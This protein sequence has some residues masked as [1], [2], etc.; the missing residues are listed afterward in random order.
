MTKADLRIH[1]LNLLF[2]ANHEMRPRDIEQELWDSIEHGKFSRNKKS[3]HVQ[4]FRALNSLV[5]EQLIQRKDLTKRKKLAKGRRK[6]RAKVQYSIEDRGRVQ[7][8]LAANAVGID[9]LKKPKSLETS[10]ILSGKT[11]EGIVQELARILLDIIER[12]DYTRSAN[13]RLLGPII[14]GF[15]IPISEEDGNIV[16]EKILILIPDE[17]SS[18]KIRAFTK[19]Q[20]KDFLQYLTSAWAVYFEEL[21]ISHG[22]LVIIHFTKRQAEGLR[23]IVELGECKNIDEVVHLAVLRYLEKC[24]SSE[25]YFEIKADGPATRMAIEKGIYKDKREAI[26]DAIKRNENRL[27]R[28]LLEDIR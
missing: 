17:R 24:D 27:T 21:N 6:G 22:D 15:P 20:Y 13:T 5:K 26:E 16:R 19:E 23:K 4:L 25:K 14:L 10:T 9:I 12:R 28:K 18:L 2:E 7:L 1:I 11:Y 3:F 8:I